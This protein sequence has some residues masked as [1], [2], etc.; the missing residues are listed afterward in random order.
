MEW[1]M[2]HSAEVMAILGGIVMLASA[3]ANV[4]PTESDN[5]VVEKLRKFVDF[6]AINWS[7]RKK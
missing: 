5:K 4:T 1:L 6:L 7:V 3:I 2:N